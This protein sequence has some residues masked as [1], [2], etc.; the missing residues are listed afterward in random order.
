MPTMAGM[1]WVVAERT[2][3]VWPRVLMSSVNHQTSGPT[4]SSADPALEGGTAGA[5]TGHHERR[6]GRH[7]E[8]RWPNLDG[9]VGLDAGRRLEPHIPRLLRR[10]ADRPVAGR[11][12]RQRRARVPGQP[13]AAGHRP[14]A[15]AAGRRQRRGLA[16]SVARRADPLVQGAPD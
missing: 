2:T 15:A 6:A 11:E 14:A 4:S 7:A 16:A 8:A 12:A 1:S 3:K 10:A 9:L 13:G 5:E